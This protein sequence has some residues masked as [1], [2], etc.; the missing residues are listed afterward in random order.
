VQ[1]NL[2]AALNTHPDALNQ[3]YNIALGERTTLNQLFQMIQ[4]A[5]RRHDA[6]LPEQKPVYREFRP[7]DIPHSQAN[8]SKAQRLLGFAPAQ[9]IEQGLDLAMSWYR[10][11]VA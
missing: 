7:G 2:L 4:G 5:L 9:R 3:V 8:I 11:N 10:Q 6:G 1:A